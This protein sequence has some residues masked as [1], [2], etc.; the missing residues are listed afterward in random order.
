[1][2]R[3]LQG[4][5][6]YK[7]VPL[8]RHAYIIQWA[9]QIVSGVLVVVLVTAF[10]A[11]ITNAIQ[12]RRFPMGSASCPASTRPPSGSTFSP[13]SPQTPSATLSESLLPTP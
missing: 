13:M 4:L 9:L 10:F 2:I 7:G 11:N 8:W 6:Y 5:T 3:A 12:D 1:M